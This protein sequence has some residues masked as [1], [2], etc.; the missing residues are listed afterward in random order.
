MTQFIETTDREIELEVE[1]QYFKPSGK[2]YSSGS[3]I[4]SKSQMFEIF[5]EV[6]EKMGRGALPDLVPGARYMCHVSVPNHPNNH[7]QIVNCWEAE[8]I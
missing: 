7:P 8:P 2:Y 4:T 3:Y 5:D 1:L 6:R